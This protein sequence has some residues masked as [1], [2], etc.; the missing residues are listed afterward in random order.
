MVRACCATG[1]G[2]PLWAPGQTFVTL[3]LRIG[4]STLIALHQHPWLPLDSA[5]NEFR[6]G[7][8]HVAC[9]AE[10]LDVG[11]ANLQFRR[12]KFV[13][14]YRS[15]QNWL[16]TFRDFYGPI[17]KTFKALDAAEQ[18][19][20]EHELLVLAGEHNTG[21]NG[22]LQIPSEYVELVAINPS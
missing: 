20:L 3:T 15:S 4:N 17:Y 9:V 7:L 22:A 12:R 6:A 5:F 8:D 1:L 13:F 14:R 11:P 2:G 19:A 21:P 16:G 18:S 10:L